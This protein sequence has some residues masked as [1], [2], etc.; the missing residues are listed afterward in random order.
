MGTVYNICWQLPSVYLERWH[1][2]PAGGRE[3]SGHEAP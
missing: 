3:E 1:Q 2:E